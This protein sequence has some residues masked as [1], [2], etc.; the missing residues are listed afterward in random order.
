[1]LAFCTQNG[2]VEWPFGL[3]KYFLFLEQTNTKGTLP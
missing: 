2:H 1:M 3:E